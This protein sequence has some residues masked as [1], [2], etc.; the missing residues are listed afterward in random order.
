VAGG[1]LAG[2]Y[3]SPVVAKLNGVA[4]SGS[5]IAGQV[6]VADSAVAASWRGMPAAPVGAYPITTVN[7]AEQ[8]HVIEPAAGGVVRIVAVGSTWAA[9]TVY[10]TNTALVSAESN[11][12]KNFYVA[13]VNGGA[14]GSIEPVWPTDGDSVVDGDILTWYDNRADLFTWTANTEIAGGLPTYI[15][16]SGC[17]FQSA[18]TFTTGDTEPDW[19]AASHQSDRAYDGT[20]YWLQM[21]TV[22]TWAPQTDYMLSANGNNRY[23]IP[24]VPNGRFYGFTVQ[25]RTKFARSGGTMPDFS[26]GNSVYYDGYLVWN[27]TNSINVSVAAGANNGEATKLLLSPAGGA[28]SIS[29][30][31]IAAGA[32]N[33]TANVGWAQAMV[34][35]ESDSQWFFG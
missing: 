3:P 11:G 24:T 5:P 22:E 28:S 6:V 26:I 27:M 32:Y 8:N 14:S 29:S 19:N 2:S 25:D 9:S 17:I 35:V 33:V 30:L 7:I 23:V 4:V 16:R 13:Y 12:S 1:D 15:S 20:G 18:G 10:D 34:Y 31:N 21:G